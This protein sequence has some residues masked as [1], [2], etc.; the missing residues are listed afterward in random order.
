MMLHS[1]KYHKSD[2]IGVLIGKRIDNSLRV[3]DVVPL[4]HQRVMT[5]PL[6]IAF[7]MIEAVYPLSD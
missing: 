3:D 2:V 1:L 6:E 7:D 4:F 5:G